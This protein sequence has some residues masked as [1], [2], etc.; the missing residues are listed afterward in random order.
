MGDIS[1]TVGDILSTKGENLST[2]VVF[3]TVGDIIFFYLSTMGDIMI[4][5]GVYYECR[6]SV[7]HRGDTLITKDDIPTLL[8][9]SPTVLNTPYGT[10]P[11]YVI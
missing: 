6:G 8:M 5:V 10:E 1:S 7:Q 4:H 11:T 2:V 3:S 9:I